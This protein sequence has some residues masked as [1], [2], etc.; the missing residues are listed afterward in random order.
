MVVKSPN[1]KAGIAGFV[2]LIVILGATEKF[3]GDFVELL[4]FWGGLIS[5]TLFTAI[6]VLAIC[7]LVKVAWRKAVAFALMIPLTLNAFEGVRSVSEPH[8]GSVSAFAVGGISAVALGLLAGFLATRIL[9][10]RWDEIQAD[11]ADT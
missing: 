5:A 2:V 9:G 10:I 8:I 1:P 3:R 4:G 11:D 6:L 7:L